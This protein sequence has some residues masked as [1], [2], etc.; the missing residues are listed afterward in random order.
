MEKRAPSK[1]R[2]G[3]LTGV[4]CPRSVSNGHGARG[5]GWKRAL[6]EAEEVRMPHGTGETGGLD[7]GGRAKKSKRGEGNRRK[8]IGKEGREDGPRRLTGW[9]NNEWKGRSARSYPHLNPHPRA[10]QSFPILWWF[11]QQNRHHS[12]LPVNESN[13]T[14]K[15][16]SHINANKQ[17]ASASEPVRVRSDH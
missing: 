4:V 1:A 3:A 8:A 14:T 17:Y 16:H 7:A 12:T 11:R 6:G 5:C 2:H 10:P 9:F 15:A 13:A